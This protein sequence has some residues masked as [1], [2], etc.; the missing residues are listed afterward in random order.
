MYD[1]YLFYDDET[2]NSAQLI[3]SVAYVIGDG[4]GVYEFIDPKSEFSR[5]NTRI[6][7]LTKADVMNKPTFAEFCEQNGFLKILSE[8]VLVAHNAASADLYHIKKSLSSYGLD[9]PEVRYVDTM[10]F[11]LSHDLPGGLTDLCA[12]YDIA[13]AAHH[14]ALADALACREIFKHLA[15]E[16]GEPEPVIWGTEAS[17]ARGSQKGTARRRI[18]GSLGYVHGSDQTIEDAL[19]ELERAGIRGSVESVGQIAGT[20]FVVTGSVPGFPGGK[21][22]ENELRRLGAKTSSSVSGKT[23][24]IAIGDN[25]GPSKIAQAKEKHI[26]VIT[27]N[28]LLDLMGR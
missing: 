20:H 10:S 22:I 3:C 13:L 4:Q 17:G 27:V 7:G 23:Q 6:H 15:G 25:A 21:A 19:L 11:A 16:F 2:A 26:P 12:H 5:Y 8:S 14:N 1:D 9:M 18:P 28:E 24:Y